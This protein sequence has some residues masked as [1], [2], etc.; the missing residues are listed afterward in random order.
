MM[1]L[2]GFVRT[3]LVI[4]A[5]VLTT[6]WVHWQLGSGSTVDLP[7]VDSLSDV[8]GGD[9][10]VTEAEFEIY[11]RALETM[12]ENHGLSVEDAADGEGL[13]LDEF[14]DVE[15]R[16]QMNDVLVDRTRESL[17]R[18]AEIVGPSRLATIVSASREAAEQDPEL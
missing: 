14:R 15:R 17:K 18:K 2:P 10:A 4:G 12:H 8:G 13:T 9:A 6:E 16:V 7:G 3:V 1:R 5:T 11:V